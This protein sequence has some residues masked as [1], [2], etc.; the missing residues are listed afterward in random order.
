MYRCRFGNER[1][2]HF[3]ANL[4]KKCDF[5]HV[6]DTKIDSNC[7]IYFIEYFG[8]RR[9]FHLTDRQEQCFNKIFFVIA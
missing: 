6:N 8:E 5:T 7:S 1:I 2:S 4:N 3:I 9:I